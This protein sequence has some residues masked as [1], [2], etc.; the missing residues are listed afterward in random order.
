MELHLPSKLKT[1]L[2]RPIRAKLIFN[3]GSGQPGES[4]QQLVN[5]LSEM[6]NQR[7]L[8]EVFIIQPDSQVDDVV[9]D[10]I[11]AGIRLI[12]VAGGDGTIDS[13]VGAMVGKDVTLGIIPTG[14]RNNV[15]FSLGIPRDIVDC[16][17]LLRHGRRLNIDVGRVH[18]GHTRHWFLEVVALGLISDLYPMADDLQHGNLAQIGGLLS[19]LVSASP[20]EMKID[21]DGKQ[22]LALT[23]HMLLIANMTYTGPNLQISADVSFKDGRLDVFT[24]TDMSKLNMLTY[25]MLS[26]GG[27]VDGIQ[28]YRAKHIKIV[29]EPPMPVLADGTQLGQGSLSVHVHPR[30]LS[31]MAGRAPKVID[32]AAA[33]ANDPEPSP[34]AAA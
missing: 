19:T 4:P 7:I 9:G 26:R 32:P 31:V 14:T 15:A 17:A 28:H 24:F 27:L 13:V 11:K 5:I 20:S 2:R 29:S 16:V 6:Q 3:P 8:P 1:S 25:A 10:A 12:V 22:Q 33:V 23:A 30:A 21:L 18:S 34:D